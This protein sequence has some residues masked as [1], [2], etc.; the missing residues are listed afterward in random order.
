M[1]VTKKTH[2][3]DME[4]TTT[5]DMELTTTVDIALTTGEEQ[6]LTDDRVREQAN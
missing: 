3:G 5:V 1:K 6:L 4:L 2:K